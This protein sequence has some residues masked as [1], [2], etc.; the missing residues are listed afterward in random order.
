MESKLVSSP[1]WSCRPISL[2][3]GQPHASVKQRQ[4]D[5]WRVTSHPSKNIEI[6]HYPRAWL[7]ARGLIFDQKRLDERTIGVHHQDEVAKA[8]QLVQEL[9][10]PHAYLDGPHLLMKRPG[11]TCYGHWLIEILPTLGI[12]KDAGGGDIKIIVQKLD[13]GM[14]SVVFESLKM[15]GVDSDSISETRTAVYEAENLVAV[16]NATDTNKGFSPNI[17]STFGKLS[18]DIDPMPHR[19]VYLERDPAGTR[20]IKNNDQVSATMR[21]MGFHIVKPETLSFRD[22][23]ALMKGADIVVGITGSALTNIAFC[24]PGTAIV[25]LAPG[26]ILDGFYWNLCGLCDLQ[27]HEI[28]MPNE[29]GGSHRLAYDAPMEVE[30]EALERELRALI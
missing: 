9:D 5:I 1:A 3:A 22:Q 11:A 7:A 25:A 4:E 16:T 12:F 19:R 23:I 28:R 29:E 15:L 13:G 24:K 17:L 18:A 26:K 8:I 20:G 2:L 30:V 6:T 14:R 10:A 21:A 27:Y